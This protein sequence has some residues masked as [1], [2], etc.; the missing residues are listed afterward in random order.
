[1]AVTVNATASADQTG[2]SSTSF[3]FNNLTIVSGA[4]RALFVNICFNTTAPSSIILTWNGVTVPEIDHAFSTVS[5]ITRIYGLLNPDIGNNVLSA[6]WTGAGEYVVDAIAFN[7]VTQ[8]SL[9]AAFLTQGSNGTGTSASQTFTGTAGNMVI[10]TYEINATT[11]ASVDHTSLYIDSSA[12]GAGACNYAN[13]STNISLGATFNS[14]Q[15]WGMI[16]AE[17]VAA[18]GLTSNILQSQICM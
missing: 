12:S 18:A 2:A 6:S 13:A 14:S 16:G 8:T 7:G 4:N 9:G 15:A 3:T 17:I 11:V 5:K 1:M 10:N